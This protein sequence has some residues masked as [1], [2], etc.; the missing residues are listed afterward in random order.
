MEISHL[1]LDGSKVWATEV[2][3]SAPIIGDFCTSA[4]DAW[5]NGRTEAI[6]CLTKE[7]KIRDLG[8]HR[9]LNVI[10]PTTQPCVNFAHLIDTL[11]DDTALLIN[12]WQQARDAVLI[13]SGQ[14]FR[15]RIKG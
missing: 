15:S 1:Y 12:R 5:T 3:H 2:I 10:W 6:R 14:G 8:P 11:N 13:A 7:V 4:L 9:I